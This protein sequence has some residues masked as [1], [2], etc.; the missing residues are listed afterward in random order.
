MLTPFA[1]T[2][3]TQ[4]EG[5][6][7]LVG[8]GE[9]DMATAPILQRQTADALQRTHARRVAIDLS[10][11]TFLDAAG[12]TALSVCRQHALDLGANMVICGARGVTRHVLELTGLWQW[13]SQPA[14]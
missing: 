6:L 13:L 3:T 10:D 9:L 2:E 11:V 14:R 8:V 7:L 12:L 1:L 5:D 4:T